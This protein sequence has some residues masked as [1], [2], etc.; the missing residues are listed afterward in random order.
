[1]HL[2]LVEVEEILTI[3]FKKKYANVSLF[4]VLFSAFSDINTSF[5]TNKCANDPSSMQHLD[6]NSRPL[7]HVHPPITSGAR[8]PP[9]YCHLK[10]SMATS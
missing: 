6:S 5:A 2:W 10:P 7:R 9:Y 1:M 4:F 8:L 3:L